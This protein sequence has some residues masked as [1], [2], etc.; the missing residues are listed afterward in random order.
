MHQRRYLFT[1]WADLE[2]LDFEPLEKVCDRLFIFIPNT[3]L[4]IPLPLVKR[5]QRL[6]KGVKWVAVADA[7]LQNFHLQL[8]FLLGSLHQ[9]VPTDIEFAIMSDDEI[10]DPLVAHI[11]EKERKCVRVR[12][13][14]T[15][16]PT[17]SP[18]PTQTMPTETIQF[19]ASANGEN[20]K[21]KESFILTNPKP[22]SLDD[23][24]TEENN[25]QK[26]AK[27]VVDRLVRSGNRPVEL[28][29]LKQYVSLSSQQ[30]TPNLIDKVV[31]FMAMNN[32]IEIFEKEVVYHF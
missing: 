10:F 21:K 19:A 7:S 32:E 25:I 27:E 29:T 23:S 18:K 8:A 2:S 22:S 31:T 26:I 11:F 1:A 15:D 12:I 30:N 14:Q 9:K 24:P 5:L 3:V 6:G 13:K 28:S 20:G 16:N 4:E 17:P